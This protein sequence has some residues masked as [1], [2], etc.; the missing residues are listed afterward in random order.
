MAAPGYGGLSPTPISWL[1]EQVGF[2]ISLDSRVMSDIF[3]VTQLN[4][5]HVHSQHCHPIQFSKTFQV[6]KNAEFF[7]HD[8]RGPVVTTTKVQCKLTTISQNFHKE[9]FYQF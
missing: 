1:G 6:L 4:H 2:N 3:N 9:P 5:E 7:F 8:I